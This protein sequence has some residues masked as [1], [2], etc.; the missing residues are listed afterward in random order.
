[1]QATATSRRPHHD[2]SAACNICVVH[3]LCV[4]LK[5]VCDCMSDVLFMSCMLFMS[6]VLCTSC[7]WLHELGVAPACV[8]AQQVMRHACRLNNL[9]S[10]GTDVGSFQILQ[11]VH[12]SNHASDS[13]HAGTL[14]LSAV[15]QVGRKKHGSPIRRPTTIAS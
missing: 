6:C 2:P 7:M 5:L 1:M 11:M 9:Q 15:L 12:C 3:V 10:L 13:L 14:A 8:A 4:L